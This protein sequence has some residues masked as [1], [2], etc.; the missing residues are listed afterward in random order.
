MEFAGAMAVAMV[1]DGL[2][3]WPD[4]LF[5]HI[6]HPVTWLGRLID[7]LDARWNREQDAP[8]TRR[9]AGFAAAVVVI[10]VASALG[11]LLQIRLAS[12]WNHV[13][14]AALRP[15]WPRACTGRRSAAGLSR[16]RWAMPCST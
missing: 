3:G 5:A 16:W 14:R 15:A 6:G 1:L 4:R 7:A 8:P 9:A 13:S 12:G 10:A 11:W 2:V